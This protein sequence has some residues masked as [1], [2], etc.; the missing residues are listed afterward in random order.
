MPNRPIDCADPPEGVTQDEIDALCHVELCELAE[1]GDGFVHLEMNL[2]PGAGPLEGCD[3]GDEDDG[4]ACDN[5][6][7]MA[8][9]GNA[10]VNVDL[11]G[12]GTIFDRDQDGYI[13]DD[14]GD[15]EECDDQNNSESDSC[16][17]NC[18][19]ARCGDD[20]VCTDDSC[21]DAI[22]GGI[23]A[24]DD[25]DNDNT[26]DCIIQISDG[27][28]HTA[29]WADGFHGPVPSCYYS[30][31]KNCQVA[32][33]GD[34]FVRTNPANAAN[35]EEC[36]EPGSRFCGQAS[37][38]AACERRCPDY[39]EINEEVDEF[40]TTRAYPTGAMMERC[41]MV[42]ED[43]YWYADDWY[44]DFAPGLSAAGNFW[45]SI[46]DGWGYAGNDPEANIRMARP[47]SDTQNDWV[48]EIVSVILGEHSWIGFPSPTQTYTNWFE[49]PDARDDTVFMLSTNGE[50]MPSD[51]PDEQN[52]MVIEYRWP[53]TERPTDY[54]FEPTSRYYEFCDGA[55]LSDF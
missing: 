17:N 46:V 45:G 38:A 16:L 26:D 11:D 54:M 7:V 47:L 43:D 41:Y 37:T 44:D 25:G 8:S 24:C 15:E 18:V 50:W 33:C 22:T 36:D 2:L 30:E 12:E 13:D 39:T 34:G 6:C 52:P 51:N 20:H 10:A 40:S 3:D 49:D 31:M 48:Y 5:D 28:T 32:T 21:E 53:S 23:E 1:C 42:T 9:C 55:M 35:A 27:E 19:E 14:S 4:D 29:D